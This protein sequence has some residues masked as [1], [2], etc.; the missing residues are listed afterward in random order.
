ME[1][2]GTLPFW[3][4]AIITHV[5]DLISATTTSLFD[6]K[7]S[8]NHKVCGSDHERGQRVTRSMN[9]QKLLPSQDSMKKWVRYNVSILEIHTESGNSLT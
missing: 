4:N 3:S 8:E 5:G 9:L 7:N 1:L 2:E 6:V